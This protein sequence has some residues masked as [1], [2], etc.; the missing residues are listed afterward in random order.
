M[1]YHW[2]YL[3]ILYGFVYFCEFN[4]ILF[5]GIKLNTFKF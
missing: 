1:I 4:C 5:L 3:I 2:K